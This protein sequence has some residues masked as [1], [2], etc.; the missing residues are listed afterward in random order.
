[1]SA[2]LF[3]FCHNHIK[4]LK[5]KI[6]KIL[7]IMSCANTI[8]PLISPLQITTQF[9]KPPY[10]DNFLTKIRNRSKKYVAKNL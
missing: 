9:P 8:Q 5:I 6:L 1:M 3:I 4:K 10:I 7:Q 2:V